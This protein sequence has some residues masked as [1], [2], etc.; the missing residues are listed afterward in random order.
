M[1]RDTIADTIAGPVK[2]LLTILGFDSST[3]GF[4]LDR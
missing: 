2:Y 1:D 3:L 4:P